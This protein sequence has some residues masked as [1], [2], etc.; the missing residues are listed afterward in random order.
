MLEGT[1]SPGVPA[2]QT[3]AICKR[4]QVPGGA[5][6]PGGI[7]T[8]RCS[9]DAT[10]GANGSC[11]YGLG[12]TGEIENLCMPRC[13]QNAPCRNGYNCINFGTTAAPDNACLLASMDGGVFDRYDAGPAAGAG[14]YNS[15]CTTDNQCR[16]PDQGYCDPAV[17]PDAG[18]SGLPGGQC[19]ADCS[20]ASTGFCGDG[21]TC[22]LFLFNTTD[23]L[24]QII[25]GLCNATCTANADGGQDGCRPAY[26]CEVLGAGTTGPGFCTSRCDNPGT[27]CGGGQ[28]CNPVTGLCN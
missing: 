10:C 26:G 2:G 3:G 17:L 28:T 6:Y 7:C 20:A 8:K 4:V 24:G 5:T 23:S 14:I 27:G 25:G 12:F 15:S 9:A 16:P 1:P 22:V 19:G 13:S 11:Q 21:G 18:P